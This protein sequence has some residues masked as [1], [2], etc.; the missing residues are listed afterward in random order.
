MEDHFCTKVKK[1]KKKLVDK[2]KKKQ[3]EKKVTARE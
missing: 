2:F 3:G 1:Q